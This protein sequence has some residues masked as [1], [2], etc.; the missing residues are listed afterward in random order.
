MYLCFTWYITQCVTSSHLVIYQGSEGQIVK[1]VC[2]VLPN[3]GV[4]IFPQALVI[5]AIHLCDLSAL[6]VPSENC[7]SLTKPH[8]QMKNSFINHMSCPKCISQNFLDIYI[9]ITASVFYYLKRNQECNCLHRIVAS[10]NIV[11]HE[12]VVGVWR[13]PTYLKQLH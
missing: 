7:D 5:E 10:V 2:E 8:L 9:N 1:Q 4:S 6:V 3:I 12:E 11:S 13:L